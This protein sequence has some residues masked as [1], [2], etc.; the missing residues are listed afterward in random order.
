MKP[1]LRRSKSATLILIFLILLPYSVSIGSEEVRLTVANHT[2]HFLHVTMNGDPYLYLRPG[3]SVVFETSTDNQMHIVAVAFYAPA[4]GIQGRVTEQF[5]IG[6]EV[7]VADCTSGGG[8]NC[9]TE[10]AF[11]SV[12]WTV[13]PEMLVEDTLAITAVEMIR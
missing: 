2:G 12:T 1:M 13:T 4:Q 8:N 10:P 6:G 5:T 3:G 9:A 11:P 7:L